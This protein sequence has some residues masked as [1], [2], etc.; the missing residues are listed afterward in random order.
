MFKKVVFI[1][2][3]SIVGMKASAQYVHF[4]PIPTYN[5]PPLPDDN[6]FID[7][8]NSDMNAMMARHNA[9][10]QA[11]ANAESTINILSQFGIRSA[12]INGQD[13]SQRYINGKASIT[14]YSIG[15]KP[16]TYMAIVIPGDNSKSYGEMVNVSSNESPETPTAY[17]HTTIVFSWNYTNS[18]DNKTG[19]ASVK[20]TKTYRPEGTVFTCHI[21]LDYSHVLD[22]GGQS[23]Q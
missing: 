10:L 23:T 19:T 22:F 4:D 7:R 16:T 3:L 9:M 5:P 21:D 13:F 11:Y 20:L 2:L 14:I 6:K 12:N 15:G 17:G 18:L 8:S 1:V